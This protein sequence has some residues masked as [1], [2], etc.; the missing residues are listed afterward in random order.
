LEKAAAGAAE[1]RVV[2]RVEGK[3]FAAVQA[4]PPYLVIVLEAPSAKLAGELLDQALEGLP[5][6]K[7]DG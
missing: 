7:G 2:Q 3:Q 4:K 6:G 1:N 5:G